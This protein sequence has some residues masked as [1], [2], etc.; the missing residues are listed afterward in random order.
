MLASH[1]N[2]PWTVAASPAARG[3]ARRRPVWPN[4]C[5]RPFFLFH[6][7]FGLPPPRPRFVNFERWCCR[8]T[9]T[10]C[11]QL[12]SC[13]PPT[14]CRWTHIPVVMVNLS[15]NGP[16]LLYIFL[17]TFCVESQTSRFQIT[18]PVVINQSLS[19]RAGLP[20]S[21]PPRRPLNDVSVDCFQRNEMSLLSLNSF[22]STSH[23]G[24]WS[25]IKAA[26]LVQPG[27]WYRAPRFC[28][29]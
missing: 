16:W 5:Q 3:S 28:E 24:P 18:V 11:Y 8:Y 21:H 4:V 22:P 10:C 20:L 14:G 6:F 1:A 9:V 23:Y 13:Q 17:A 25:G 29:V 19:R 2:P 15:A 26:S 7:L 27:H 12:R